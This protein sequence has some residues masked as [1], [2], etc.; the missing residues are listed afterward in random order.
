M[1]CSAAACSAAGTARGTSWTGVF[2]ASPVEGAAVGEAGWDAVPLPEFSPA[3]GAV[4]GVAAAGALAVCPA[5]PPDGDGVG[6]AWVESAA[7]DAGPAAESEGA[8]LWA[9]VA[10]SPL[11]LGVVNTQPLTSRMPEMARMDMNREWV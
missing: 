9:T 1:V 6:E 8:A 11:S 10:G 2:A 7:E 5:L 3:V 4:C